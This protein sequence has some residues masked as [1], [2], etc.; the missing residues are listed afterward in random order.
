M[1]AD[2]IYF[3]D[4]DFFKLS[5]LIKKFFFKRIFILF[6][7]PW[8]KERHKKRRL[9]NDNFVN[10]LLEISSNDTQILVATDH[11]EYSTQVIKSFSKGKKFKLVLYKTNQLVLN[12]LEICPTKYFIKAK[13][14]NK[15]INFFL[16][17]K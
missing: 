1:G 7:D 15:S 14:E 9:I 5:N 16:F 10:A 13:N 6:P 3:T 11:Q 17:K 2:N 12:G 4:L 8:P